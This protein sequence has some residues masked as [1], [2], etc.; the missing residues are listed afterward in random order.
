MSNSTFLHHDLKLLNPSF[1]SKLVDILTELEHL[2]RYRLDD[3]STPTYIFNELRD[4]FHMLE[5]LSSATEG[6]RP[7]GRRICCFR[8][9]CWPEESDFR[10]ADGSRMAALLRTLPAQC[11][12][13]FA[14][15]G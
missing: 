10:G 3:G 11:A 6:A 2:R 12:G 15:Q 5:R 7:L 9:P 1:D 13:L 8:R 4:I 14:A